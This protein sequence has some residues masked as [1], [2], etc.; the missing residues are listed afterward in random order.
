[1]LLMIE[2]HVV[3]KRLPRN[4]E[5]R[6][7]T[8]EFLTSEPRYVRKGCRGTLKIAILMQFL[9]IEPHFVRNKLPRNFENR[10]FT[11]EFLTIEFHF[12]R[13]KLPRNFEN[14]HFT[15]V[16]D[17]RTSFQGSAIDKGSLEI[18]FW[19]LEYLLNG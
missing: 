13:K 1:M 15:A 19:V 14:C 4:F 3:R 10:I 17:D 9:M 18:G 6:I 5:N 16:F 12:E 8:S 2:L 11:S 7:F